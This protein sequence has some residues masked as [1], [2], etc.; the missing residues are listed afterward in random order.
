MFCWGCFILW[1]VLCFSHA[2]TFG[3]FGPLFERLCRWTAFMLIP[4]DTASLLILFH[5]PLLNDRGFQAFSGMAELMEGGSYRAE[6]SAGGQN[7]SGGERR[8]KIQR[9]QIK[10]MSWVCSRI[11][12][13]FF[14]LDR[15]IDERET[16]PISKG[17]ICPFNACVVQA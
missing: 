14:I 11:F 17:A 3:P 5:M 10:G 12:S 9:S 4:P 13:L 1:D 2:H 6:Q 7:K 8:R 16:F 15:S